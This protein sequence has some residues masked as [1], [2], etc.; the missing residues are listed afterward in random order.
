[1]A[2]RSIACPPCAQLRPDESAIL[3]PLPSVLPKPP[4]A[5]GLVSTAKGLEYVLPKRASDFRLGPSIF[6]VSASSLS[7]AMGK[8]REEHQCAL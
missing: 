4:R 5:T 1:M 2:P 7:R 3:L 6:K 8:T